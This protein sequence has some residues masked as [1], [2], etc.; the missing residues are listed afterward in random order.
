MH[1]YCFNGS[2]GVVDRCLKR[3]KNTY[4]AFTKMVENFSEEQIAA[5][6]G[7]HKGRLLVE[8][9]VPYFWYGD[10][11]FCTPAVIRMTAATIQVGIALTSSTAADVFQL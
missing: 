8:T 4:F 5:V 3:F 6:R 10:D 7:L 1:L 11:H 2:S 9:D